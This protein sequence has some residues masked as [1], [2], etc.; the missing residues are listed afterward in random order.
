VILGLVFLRNFY[1]IF[2]TEKDKIGIA[3]HN[4]TKSKFMVGPAWAPIEPIV[5]PPVAPPAPPSNNGGNPSPPEEPINK[6][7]S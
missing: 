7:N 5:K 1:M 3:L 6:D 4:I 2:D